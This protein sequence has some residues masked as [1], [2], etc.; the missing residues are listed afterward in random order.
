MKV[1]E[2]QERWGDYRKPRPEEK[3]KHRQPEETEVF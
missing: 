3:W 1:T 2:R